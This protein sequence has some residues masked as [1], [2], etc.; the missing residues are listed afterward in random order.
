MATR[1]HFSL[2]VTGLAPCT[3][4]YH[5]LHAYRI[6]IELNM[7][8]KNN[9]PYSDASVIEVPAVRIGDVLREQVSGM[10]RHRFLHGTLF[11]GLISDDHLC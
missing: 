6:G 4:T 9:T 5:P 10:L 3:D 2:S 8:F 1:Y 11:V 7:T